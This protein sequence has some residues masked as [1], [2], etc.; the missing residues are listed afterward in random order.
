M[1][2]SGVLGGEELEVGLLPPS[3]LGGAQL[4]CGFGALVQWSAHPPFSF[5]G[6]PHCF[7]PHSPLRTAGW[8]WMGSLWLLVVTAAQRMPTQHQQHV[9]LDAERRY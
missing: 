9:F 5:G 6:V 3:R 1:H 2:A 4:F 7:H 8:G